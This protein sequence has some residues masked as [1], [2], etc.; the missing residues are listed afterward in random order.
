[1]DWISARNWPKGIGCA[2]AL[3]LLLSL[4]SFQLDDPTFFNLRAHSRGI[5]NLLGLPGALIGGSLLELLGT[6]AL[7]APLL[8]C[9]W[10]LTRRNRP[11]PHHYLFWSACA[12]LA[13]SVL[14]GLIA[15]SG[16]PRLSD[17]GLV[18]QAGRQWVA[19]T[20][21]PWLAGALLAY[22]VAYAG[23]G[24]LFA[25][26][27]RS[28]LRDVRLFVGWFGRAAVRQWISGWRGVRT[29]S[30]RLYR[31]T[32]AAALGLTRKARL[33]LADLWFMLLMPP[34][35]LLSG[36]ASL[37]APSLARI[38]ARRHAQAKPAPRPRPDSSAP[39][40]A[41][42]GFDAWFAP[43]LA[44]GASATPRP[45]RVTDEASPASALPTPG[46]VRREQGTGDVQPDRVA[47]ERNTARTKA[48][49]APPALDEVDYQFEN[50]EAEAAWRKRFRRYARNLDLDWQ[51]QPWGRR[52]T[53]EPEESDGAT[54]A[55]GHEQR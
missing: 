46:A 13:L 52:E 17:P 34:R 39:A 23:N 30:S 45:A 21:G 43:T 20:T 15:P 12:L 55:R 6:S 8:L 19:M 36:V 26:P 10:F 25:P 35:R 37:R 22:V 29:G 33:G 1:M 38:K 9:N 41:D 47:A 18:G 7:A 44:A 50:A 5:G 31:V 11:P 40:A 54:D 49:Q 2:L 32:D 3:L 4:L 27:L 48:E 28:A 53:E 14:H 24:V 16:E 42:D 51:A